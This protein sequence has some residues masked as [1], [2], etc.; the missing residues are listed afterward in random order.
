[1]ITAKLTPWL[2][3]M[4]KQLITTRVVLVAKLIVAI[5][6]MIVTS[7]EVV[8]IKQITNIASSIA[9]WVLDGTGALIVVT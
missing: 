9:T 5:T 3:L 1:M 8:G 6:R 2:E 4:I 7:Q